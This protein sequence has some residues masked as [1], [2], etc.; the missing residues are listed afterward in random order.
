MR[1]NLDSGGFRR[2]RDKQGERQGGEG[3]SCQKNSRY[4]GMEETDRA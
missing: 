1:D 3:H 2:G 4:K